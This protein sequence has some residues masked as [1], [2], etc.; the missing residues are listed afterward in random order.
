MF[1][2]NET[3]LYTVAEVAEMFYAGP[4]TIYKLIREHKLPAMRVGRSWLIPHAALDKF[5]K[6][7]S[8]LE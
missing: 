4:N 3:E 2:D 7:S 5:I 1:K 8:G 6:T